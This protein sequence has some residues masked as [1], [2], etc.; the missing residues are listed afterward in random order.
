MALADRLSYNQGFPS[1]NWRILADDL[2][3]EQTALL[4]AEAHELS[5]LAPAEVIVRLH[6]CADS[7][8]AA[9]TNVAGTNVAGTA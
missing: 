6:E 1:L 4:D 8:A 9:D 3:A 5:E 2:S 7:I